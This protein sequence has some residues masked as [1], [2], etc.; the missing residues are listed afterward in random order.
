M[1]VYY[2]YDVINKKKIWVSHPFLF[3]YLPEVKIRIIGCDVAC[4]AITRK[5]YNREL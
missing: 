2:L 1:I 3:S 5:Q 4:V